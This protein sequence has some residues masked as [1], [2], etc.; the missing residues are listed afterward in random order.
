VALSPA[1][2]SID[3]Q[4]LQDAQINL[5]RDDPRGFLALSADT[6]AHDIELRPIQVRRLLALLRRL[7]L[8]RGTAWVFEPNG[9]ALQRAIKRG[10]DTLMGDLFRRGAFA[11]ATPSQGFR[12]VTDDT[13]NTPREADAGRL[14]VELH[15]APAQAMR[16]IA[17]RLLQSG[18][19]LTVAEEL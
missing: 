8:R 5:L 11:G 17:V 16:F 4:R 2:P 13:V 9:P 19:R 6:L 14:I 18:E 7:A 1:V 12:V 10:F 3:R 15:V